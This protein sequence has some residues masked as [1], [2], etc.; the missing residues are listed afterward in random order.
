MSSL[1]DHLRKGAQILESRLITQGLRTTLIWAYAR[2]VARVSGIPI[3]KYSRITPQIYVGAQ[4]GPP[5]M[6]ILAQWGIRGTIN[7]R[8]EFDD[9]NYGLIQGEYCYIPTKDDYAPSL[10]ELARGVHFMDKILQDGGKVYIHCAG[11]VGRAPTMAAAYLIYH[12]MDLSQAIATIQATRPFIKLTPVQIE[13][14]T[15]WQRQSHAV[16]S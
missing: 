3:E 6:E 16:N 5:G 2:G 11:G 14:L 8:S 4:H 12:G 13:R 9:A 15:E 1:T 10:E 7:L